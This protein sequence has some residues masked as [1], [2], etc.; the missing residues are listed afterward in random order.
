MQQL[1]TENESVKKELAEAR[2]LIEKLQQAA[3][4]QQQQQHYALYDNT[5]ASNDRMD[6]HEENEGLGQSR[7]APSKNDMPAVEQKIRQ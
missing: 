5:N 2:V 7:H 3:D 1:L 4:Q 6:Y